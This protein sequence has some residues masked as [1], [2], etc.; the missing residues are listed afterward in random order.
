[1]SKGMKAGLG[2][3]GGQDFLPHGVPKSPSG[4]GLP[5]TQTILKIRSEIC[6]TFSL[7]LV[8][9]LDLAGFGSKAGRHMVIKYLVGLNIIIYL[10]PMARSSDFSRGNFTAPS[11]SPPRGYL[12]VSADTSSCRSW[13]GLEWEVLQSRLRPG[14]LQAPHS[15]RSVLPQMPMLRE[16][17]HSAPGF[18]SHLLHLRLAF[19]L[20]LEPFLLPCSLTLLFVQATRSLPL[21]YSPQCRHCFPLRSR[22]PRAPPWAGM[23]SPG[24]VL[25]KYRW[26]NQKWS[27]A[28]EWKLFLQNDRI[29]FQLK[30]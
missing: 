22:S 27:S 6:L 10:H 15:T 30:K 25:S 21:S 28:Y 23:G 1:M 17:R 5:W 3:K 7:D 18:H 8:L 13:G 29:T 11:P 2:I 19:P 4:V 12:V 14:R 16:L 20:C 24:E 9:F 26:I